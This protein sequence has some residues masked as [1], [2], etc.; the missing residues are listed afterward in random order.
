MIPIK[1]QIMSRHFN[2]RI[3]IEM[4]AHYYVTRMIYRNIVQLNIITSLQY[5]LLQRPPNHL[6]E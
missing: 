4:T 5:L 6:L 2:H 1:A 3:M